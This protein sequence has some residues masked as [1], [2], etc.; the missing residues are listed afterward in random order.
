MPV[1][2][3]ENFRPKSSGGAPDQPGG[4]L[5]FRILR[6]EFKGAKITRILKAEQ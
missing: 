3:G 2:R 1:C 4:L 5:E 6:S